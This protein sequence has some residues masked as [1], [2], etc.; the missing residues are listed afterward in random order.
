ME[1]FRLRK[2]RGAEV[3]ERV[4]E[5]YVAGEAGPQLA[6]RFD[7]G[8]AN[9]RK[10]AMREG[11]TRR[12]AAAASDP[13]ILATQPRLLGAG[14]QGM[15]VVVA[16]PVEARARAIAQAAALLGEGRAAEASAIL[17]AAEALGRI[18]EAAVPGPMDPAQAEAERREQRGVITEMIRF[19][20]ERRA[21]HLVRE[22][23]ES[24]FDGRGHYTLFA[25]KWRAAH[26]GPEVAEHDRRRC[27]AQGLAD[28]FYDTEG[29][30]LPFGE[31]AQALRD[32]DL[33]PWGLKA[34]WRETEGEA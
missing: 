23:L 19:E 10:K 32:G 16:D 26:L 27:E 34:H 12:A 30:L 6:R 1:H 31:I 7:V 15:D 9:L 29:G 20:V 17:K 33:D 21:E 8:L 22:L 25:L 3:W 28:R 18:T 24:D 13:L 4:R 5:A 14:P 11:W 2:Y